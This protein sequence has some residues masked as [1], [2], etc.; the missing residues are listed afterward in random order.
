MTRWFIPA[1]TRW[2]TTSGPSARASGVRTRSLTKSSRGSEADPSLSLSRRLYANS[3]GV[4]GPVK[5]HPDAAL[6]EVIVRG[7]SGAHEVTIVVHDENSARNKGRE[8]VLENVL[9]G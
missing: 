8:Q 1:T 6:V 5:Q 3:S 2:L 4:V 9:G 7:L